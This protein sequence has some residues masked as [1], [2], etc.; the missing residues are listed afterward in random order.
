MFFEYFCHLY[1]SSYI[2]EN[3]FGYG[4]AEAYFQVYT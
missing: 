2:Q 4:N 3:F 1:Y